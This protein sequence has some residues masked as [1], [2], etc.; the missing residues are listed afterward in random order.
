[1]YFLRK[2][3]D[4]DF[5]LRSPHVGY[6]HKAALRNSQKCFKKIRST[7]ISSQE[8]HQSTLNKKLR[9]REEHCA[10]VVLSWCTL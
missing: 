8:Q 9:Y 3:D 5:T 4:A 6:V 1:M 7:S 2:N 10:S